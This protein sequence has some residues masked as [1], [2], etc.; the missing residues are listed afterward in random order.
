MMTD[1]RLSTGSRRIGRMAL[2]MLA[3]VMAG[4]VPGVFADV[5]PSEQDRT[6]AAIEQAG[7]KVVR[8]VQRPGQ[9]GCAR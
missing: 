7:G 4:L 1:A 5:E 8:D 3:V 6:I 2:P 9:A